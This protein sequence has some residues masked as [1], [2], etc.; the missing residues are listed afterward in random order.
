MNH[1]FDLKIVGEES[2][3]PLGGTAPYEVILLEKG[4]HVVEAKIVTEDDFHAHNTFDA[5]EEVVEKDFGLYALTDSGLRV[6][7]PKNSVVE[8]RLSR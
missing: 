7:M 6:T 3:G 2:G 5:P 4:Y 1:I 8:I